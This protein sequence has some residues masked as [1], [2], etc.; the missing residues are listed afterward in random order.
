MKSSP[1][2][3]TARVSTPF[4]MVDAAGRLLGKGALAVSAC[5]AFREK[6]LADRTALS[7]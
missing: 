7:V 6:E 5:V 1:A 2:E 4:E 3:S